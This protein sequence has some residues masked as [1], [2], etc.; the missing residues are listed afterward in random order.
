MKTNKKIKSFLYLYA[1]F[2]VSCF[3]IITMAK[4]TGIISKDKDIAVAKWDVSLA[5][6]DNETLPTIVIGDSSTYQEYDL[7]VTS[8]S[9]VAINYALKISNVPHDLIIKIDDTN[10]QATRNSII[11][12]NF[13]SFNANDT[14]IT[15]IHKLKF[16]VPINSNTITGQK[17]DIDVI[18]TQVN[19]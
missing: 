4:Y 6:N 19:L 17:L 8:K 1:L 10:Y 5:G 3:T 7:K 2:F 18:F 13:G 9:E 11:I 12:D 14:D 16:M 15:H